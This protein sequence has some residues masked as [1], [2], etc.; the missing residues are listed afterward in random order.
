MSE[1]G[2]VTDILSY[3]SLNRIVKD[4]KKER[5]IKGKL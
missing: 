3:S 2:W 1:F 4:E 5:L